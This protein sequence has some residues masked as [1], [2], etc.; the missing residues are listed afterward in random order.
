MKKES[1]N[2]LGIIDVT[3]IVFIILK[4]LNVITWSWWIVFTP[5]WIVLALLIIVILF[6]LATV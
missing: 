1:R 4:L 6:I 2:G 5:L 3:Q